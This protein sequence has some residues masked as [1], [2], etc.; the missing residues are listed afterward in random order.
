MYSHG[1][2]YISVHHEDHCSFRL[3]HRRG[4]CPAE[5]DGRHD[6]SEQHDERDERQHDERQHAPTA[7][8]YGHEYLEWHERNE[9]HEQWTATTTTTTAAAGNFDSKMMS[10]STLKKKK[11]KKKNINFVCG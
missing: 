3:P 6:A 8:V 7:N 1:N 2:F 10:T 11:R 9:Q 4:F 5:L